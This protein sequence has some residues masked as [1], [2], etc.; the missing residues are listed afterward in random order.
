MLLNGGP[1]A[2]GSR[3]QS[4]IASST[5][6]SEY[7][8]GHLASQEI[9]WIRSLLSNLGA[10]QPHPTTLHSDN[11]SAIKLVKNPVFHTRTKH[12]DLK[13]HI[14]RECEENGVIAITYICTADQIADILTKPLPRDKFERMRQLLG[15]TE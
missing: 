15:L 3:K 8:A 1:I 9:T 4:C 11:Q 5:T 12:I 10:H 6:E 7:I 13:Y 14:I 2:W